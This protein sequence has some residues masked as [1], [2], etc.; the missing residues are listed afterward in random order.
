M[1]RFRPTWVGPE[2]AGCGSEGGVGESRVVGIP[3][4]VVT[5]MDQGMKRRRAAGQMGLANF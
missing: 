4:M 5:W 1:G 2:C 3:P